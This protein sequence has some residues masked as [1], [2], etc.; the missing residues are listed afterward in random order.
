MN[1]ATDA[2]DQGKIIKD[3]IP[4]IHWVIN[5]YFGLNSKKHANQYDELFAEGM[6]I[7]CKIRFDAS[8][9][10]TFG[11]YATL[12][13]RRGLR[14]HITQQKRFGMKLVKCGTFPAVRSL[15]VALMNGF[16]PS[17]DLEY[18]DFE[19]LTKYVP[20]GKRREVLRMRYVENKTIREIAKE[21][22]I[23]RTRTMQ[24]HNEAIAAIR[25]CKVFERLKKDYH[26]H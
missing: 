17:Y 9:G 23:S 18:A 24:Y 14:K 4:L 21:W 15:D 25:K 12:L 7:L 22:G 8:K 20:N 3:N 2:T 26:S 19:G 16:Q 10:S 5:R 6:Y 13:L 1:T 11:N